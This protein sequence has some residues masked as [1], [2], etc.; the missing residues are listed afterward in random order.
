MIVR[1]GFAALLLAATAAPVAADD[2]R[3]V[4]SSRQFT[5]AIDVASFTGPPTARL[6]W[7]VQVYRTT[8]MHGF[9]YVLRQVEFDCSSRTSVEA[10]FAAYQAD[11]TVVAS[12]QTRGE[13]SVV[14]P[15]SVSASELEAV[16]VGPPNDFG[17]PDLKSIVSFARAANSLE[18]GL[19]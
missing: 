12:D 1:V 14:F 13:R 6:G 4:T 5:V 9:D 7:L 19:E 11:G 10:A 3:L 16:C 18:M 8:Q 2:W 15:G 17:L